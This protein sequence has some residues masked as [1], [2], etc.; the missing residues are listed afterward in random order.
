MVAASC[1][2]LVVRVA[3]SGCSVPGSQCGGLDRAERGQGKDSLCEVVVCGLGWRSLARV[4]W[5]VGAWVLWL[6]GSQFRELVVGC[7]AVPL[8]RTMG[9]ARVV[10]LG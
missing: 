7:G 5:L 10:S 9:A 2:L 8:H 4:V 6:A 3:V 1:R